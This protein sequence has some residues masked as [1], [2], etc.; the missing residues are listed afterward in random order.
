MNNKIKKNRQELKKL[1]ERII[2]T[3][4]RGRI[5]SIDRAVSN[6]MHLIVGQAKSGGK[7]FFIGNGASAAI[8]SHMA[9]DFW[10]N[11]GIKAFAFNDSSL[12]TC[13]SNDFG[14]KFVFEKPIEVFAESGDILIAISSSGQSE[15]ILKGVKAARR[16][17]MKVITLSGFSVHNPLRKLGEI[18]FYVPSSSYG[19][20]EVTHHFICHCLLDTIINN[21]TKLFKRKGANA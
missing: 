19:H 3:N 20:V 12:L 10:K 11:T 4:E 7:L 15:N 13:V 8:A 6:L 21:K 5:F 16:K 14:Y 1:L 17:D 9:T 2:A 18:N